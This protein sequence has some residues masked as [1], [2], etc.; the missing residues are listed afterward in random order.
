M[1][2]PRR[3]R[4]YVL[5]Y[6]FVLQQLTLTTSTDEPAFQRLESLLIS[7]IVTSS[8]PSKPQGPTFN[9]P[10]GIPSLSILTLASTMVVHPHF[11]TRPITTSHS[12]ASHTALSYL[13]SVNSIVGPLNSNLG[14]AFAFAISPAIRKRM[15]SASETSKDH[16][17]VVN[18]PYVKEAS[19]FSAGED[20]WAVVGW[21]FNC[22]VLYPKRWIV[23][24]SWLEFMVEVLEDDWAERR[25]LAGRTSPNGTAN[26]TPSSTPGDGPEVEIL[27]KS[28]IATYLSRTRDSG[29]AKERVVRSIFARG[30]ERD[31]A[32]F[33]EVFVNETKE[34]KKNTGKKSAKLDVD[35]GQY[36]DYADEDTDEDLDQG[37]DMI[38]TSS[39]EAPSSDLEDDDDDK[40]DTTESKDLTA[41]FGGSSA[42]SLRHRLITLLSSVSDILPTSSTSISQLY[43]SL[44]SHIKPLPLSIFPFFLT[45]TPRSLAPLSPAP[46]PEHTSAI[47]ESLLLSLLTDK[48]PTRRDRGDLNQ[49]I[50]EHHYL[51]YTANTNSVA[52]NAK[53]SLCFEV[54]IHWLAQHADGGIIWSGHFQESV[55]KG[56][57]ARQDKAKGYARVDGAK[58]RKEGVDKGVLEISGKRLKLLAQVERLKLEG[59]FAE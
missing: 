36:G 1:Y 51:P 6:T 16:H 17:A 10:S 24:Q 44:S 59:V 23:W 28:T 8:L 29:T 57:K 19:V 35:K 30:S 53:V 25:R 37:E 58:K 48:A 39:M 56:V 46:S 26:S 32:E 33:K 7:G 34:K 47:I 27:E 42:L 31:I 20:F 55:E 9:S 52:D 11:T 12:A 38:P 22:S 21:A 49:A 40:E 14:D 3:N 18:T 2:R 54:L 45:S 15:T 5:R 43:T 50:L 41:P 13:H 4:M